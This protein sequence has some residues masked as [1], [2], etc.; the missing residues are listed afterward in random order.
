MATIVLDPGH[1]GTKTVGGSS[2]NNATG[3]NGLKEKEV[4]LKLALATEKALSSQDLRIVLTRREDKNLGIL[5]RAAVAKGRRA[6]V[7]VSIHFNAPGGSDPAQGTETWIG[8]GHTSL[9]KA[10]ATVVQ[11]EV[12]AATGYRNRGVKVGNVSGV[13]KPGNHH[14]STANCLVEVSFLSLQPD[15]EA[16]LRKQTYIDKLGQALAKAIRE[17][18]RERELLPEVEVETAEQL[19]AEDAASARAL[20]LIEDEEALVVPDELILAESAEVHDQAGIAPDADEESFGVPFSALD[21]FE[22]LTEIAPDSADEEAIG[23]EGLEVSIEPTIRFGPNAKSGDV[24]S[25]SRR[26]LVDIMQRAGLTRLEISSTSRSPAD[27]ARVMYNNLERF[28]VAHQKSLYGP[29]GDRVID[30]YHHGKRRGQDASTIKARMTSE[31]IRIGPTRVSRHAADPNILNVFD[32]APSSVARKQAF[33]REVRAD[34]RV[35][36]FIMPP[37]D[38]GYHLEIPQSGDGQ[39]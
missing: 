7:F 19:E 14:P 31:I 11:R 37:T 13:I 3:P 30:V 4:T 18:L 26:V 32:V 35:T 5:E 33:E 6:E 28:G 1:G 24:T 8:T 21:A 20:G 23:L 39:A 34:R 22:N 12:R 38:P 27:Q 25:F 36:R 2:P 16:R 9:S 10:L 29:A 15:E 17:H